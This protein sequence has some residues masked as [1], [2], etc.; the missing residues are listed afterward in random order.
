VWLAGEHPY[1]LGGI[2]A[3]YDALCA[4]EQLGVF[5]GADYEA[6]CAELLRRFEEARRLKLKESVKVWVQ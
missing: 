3:A 5:A 1:R 2:I 4:L 6:A